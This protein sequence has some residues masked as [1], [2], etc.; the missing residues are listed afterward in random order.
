MA[1]GLDYLVFF[2][3]V[4][5]TFSLHTLGLNLQWGLTGLF[6]VGIAGFAAIGAYASA[7]LTGPD[8][9]GSLGGLGLPVAVGWGGAMVASGLAALG[10]G[11]LT[12]RLRQDHLAIA[13]FGIAVVIQLLAQNLE[14]L[15]GGAFGLASLPRPLAGVV[16]GSSAR[17]AVFLAVLAALVLLAWAALARLTQGPWGRVLRAI[18][19]DETAAAALGKSPFRHRLEAF[20]IGAALMG[21][22]GA[23]Y[24]HFIGF[25]APQDFQ[26]ILTFQVWAMLI[27][28]GSGSHSG[29]I[30]GGI[31]VWAV[32][33]A[34]GTLLDL[35]LPASFQ[36]RGAALQIVLIGAALIAILLWRPQGLI[37]ERPGGRPR[38]GGR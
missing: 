37:A 4:A 5:L 33:T 32:W 18:R 6:N 27:V 23:V 13:T 34:S 28:G 25:V 19:E 15:T 11:A 36:V 16:E 17:N 22:G 10:V 2:L 14:P 35:V 21:L 8:W 30:L 7:L 31:L 24:A 1:G 20:V 9:P 3:V 29:A 12:L 38:W 26:A